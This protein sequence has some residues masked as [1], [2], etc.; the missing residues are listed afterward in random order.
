MASCYGSFSTSFA[1]ACAGGQ[2]NSPHKLSVVDQAL[3][4]NQFISQNL[5]G[6]FRIAGNTDISAFYLVDF[7]GDSVT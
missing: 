1:I 3:S 5:D 7:N 6:A 2:D 4:V